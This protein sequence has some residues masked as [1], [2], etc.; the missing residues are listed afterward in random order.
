MTLPVLLA[1]VAARWAATRTPAH[2]WVPDE[3]ETDVTETINDIETALDTWDMVTDAN[4]RKWIRDENECV[5]GYVGGKAWG[6]PTAAFPAAPPF[7]NAHA[8][9]ATA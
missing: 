5:R 7:T 9:G 8:E 2:G 1:H 4:G 3:S 6:R